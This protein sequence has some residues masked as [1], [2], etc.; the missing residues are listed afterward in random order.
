MAAKIM[1]TLHLRVSEF[2]DVYS[3]GTPSTGNP[4][5]WDGDV[6]WVTPKDLSTHAGVYIGQGD[7]CITEQGLSQSSACLLAADT[8]ILSSRAPVGY[9]AIA[10][11][12]L[13][14]SQGCKNLR[15]KD[16]IAHP[17][18]VYY[19][20]KNNTSILQSHATG[21]T[22]KELSTSRLKNIT[23]PLPENIAD[24][25]T[26]ASI[27]SS[28][29]DL[30]ENN[31]RRIRLL[32]QAARMLYEEWFVRLRF[33]GHEHVLVDAGL[34]AGWTTR[35]IAEVCDTVGGGTP[36]TQVSEY[37]DG[38]V[39]WV[40]PSDVTRNDCL[41]LLD[42]E[43]KITEKGLRESSAKIVPPATILMTSRASVGFF[44]LMD[45]EAATNQGFINIIPRNESLRMYLLFN[46]MNR[47]SEIRSNAKGTT[48][49]EISKGRF[50]AMDVIVPE[51]SVLK[52]F[53]HITSD[54]VRQA[55][56][57][58]RSAARL[59]DARNLLLPRLM[60]GIIEP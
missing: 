11:S 54:L 4:D 51:S 48:Y 26:I 41:A 13:A 53:S 5:Y 39:T 25:I 19:L 1:K 52:Q 34:P 60:N 56:C 22:Y 9:V 21:S 16:G 15:C 58:K 37:W 24:Q 28:Y 42:S 18:Y 29:D 2:A 57:L 14:T 47:V 23:L 27:L 49:P 45:R 20:L 46:L 10:Q 40:V 35:R 6:A 30:I 31:R 33:P 50:R 36:S 3:G 7:R 38:D 32:E 12:P 43:R 44:A 55:R 59:A 8:V 17:L